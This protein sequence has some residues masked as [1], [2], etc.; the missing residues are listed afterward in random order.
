[1]SKKIAYLRPPQVLLTYTEEQRIR[2]DEQN[3]L[4]RQLH[5]Q[6]YPFW[7]Q[8]TVLEALVQRFDQ[9]VTDRGRG[10]RK[11]LGTLQIAIYN[12]YSK[13]EEEY[14]HVGFPDDDVKQAVNDRLNAYHRLFDGDKTAYT[15][16][17]ELARQLNVSQPLVAMSQAIKRGGPTNKGLRPHTKLIYDGVRAMRPPPEKSLTSYGRNWVK[18]LKYHLELDER[19]PTSTEQE[20]ITWIEKKSDDKLHTELRKLLKRGDEF[21]SATKN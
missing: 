18:K 21:Q 10:M 4:E 19:N 9:C 12:H 7:M 13:M 15:D 1:M 14:H 3:K 8:A 2:A 17:L 6:V 11:M 20:A 5:D 16:L